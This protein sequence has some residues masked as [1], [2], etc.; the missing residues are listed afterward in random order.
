MVNGDQPSALARALCISS[1]K[2]SCHCNQ[3]DPTKKALYTEKRPSGLDVSSDPVLAPELEVFRNERNWILMKIVNNK[4]LCFHA[5]GESLFSNFIAALT[6][7]DIYFGA[8]RANVNDRVKTFH[9]CYVGPNTGA[10]K[11]GKASLQKTAAFSVIDAHGELPYV[12]EIAEIT[13]ERVT[14]DIARLMGVQSDTVNLL[15]T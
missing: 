10:M 3:M 7:D 11:K 6:E 12:C 14:S 13:P 8:I 9:V 2:N 15:L 4:Q 1:A 5:S